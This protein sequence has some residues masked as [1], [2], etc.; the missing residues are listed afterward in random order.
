MR[1]FPGLS[2]L[3][4]GGVFSQ[5]R[6]LNGAVNWNLPPFSFFTAEDSAVSPT[7]FMEKEK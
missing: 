2:V 6:F 7:E 5:R 4:I 3:N 1:V